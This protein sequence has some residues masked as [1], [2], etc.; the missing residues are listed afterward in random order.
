MIAQQQALSDEGEGEDGDEEDEE[1]D[2]DEEVAEG[3]DQEDDEDEG[4]LS[5]FSL[6]FSTLILLCRMLIN[7]L[8]DCTEETGDE[9][10]GAVPVK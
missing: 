5:L 9:E 6:N 7:R 2:D 4:T 1:G 3:E 10:E 8:F